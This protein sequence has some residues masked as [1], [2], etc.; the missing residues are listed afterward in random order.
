MT[1]SKF[2]RIMIDIT[3][4]IKR[5]LVLGYRYRRA[6]DG[7]DHDKQRFLISVRVL[8]AVNP[9]LFPSEICVHQEYTNCSGN[10][11]IQRDSLCEQ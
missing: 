5:S 7:E 11:N 10:I 1:Q 8:Q 6:V 2:L 4:Q 3:W 9:S